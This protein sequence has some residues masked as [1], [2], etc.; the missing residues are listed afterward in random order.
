MEPVI[1]L[2]L[3]CM[4][5]SDR[6]TAGLLSA[7]VVAAAAIMWL[8]PP[9]MAT[10]APRAVLADV[11]THSKVLAV[12]RAVETDGTSANKLLVIASVVDSDSASAGTVSDAFASIGYDLNS[13]RA[14]DELVPRLFLTSLPRDIGDVREPAIRKSIF[15]KT[16]LPLVL[17]VNEEILAQRGRLWQLR[18]KLRMGQL[19]READRLWLM[20]M[21][22]RY[23]T[24]SNDID[25]LIR[26]VDVIPP[27]L[28]LAQAAEESGWGT[29]RFVREGNALFGQW[30]FSDKKHLKPEQRDG[31][32]RHQVMAFE[33]LTFAT[34]AYM[35]N[36]NT[37]PAYASLRQERWNM[38]RVGVAVD[39]YQLAGT[40][41]HYSERGDK[42]IKSLRIIILANGLEALDQARLHEDDSENKPSI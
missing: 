29:S 19:L 4:I 6:F 37:H 26:R 13:I 28:A 30:V 21:A 2:K 10:A 32:K 27:S 22:E 36:L 9:R 40:L 12:A 39:G 31:D 23:K 8:H 35:K 17:Q 33:S 34:M 14:G 38:R 1:C 25:T 16:V 42:Y 5:I 20:V 7:F 18:F 3:V 11:R 41:Q 24:Q 15:L